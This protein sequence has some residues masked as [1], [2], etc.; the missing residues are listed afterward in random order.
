MQPQEVSATLQVGDVLEQGPRADKKTTVTEHRINVT[1]EMRASVPVDAA[2]SQV[3]RRADQSVL[4]V[5]TVVR[6]YINDSLKAQALH[7]VIK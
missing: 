4:H 5:P 3:W 1:P 7:I 2:D 6:V